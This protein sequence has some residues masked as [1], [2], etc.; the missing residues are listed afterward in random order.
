M[1]LK[2]S[3]HMCSGKISGRNQV[4][5]KTPWIHIEVW[6]F[7]KKWTVCENGDILLTCE[8]GSSNSYLFGSYVK[9]HHS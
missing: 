7:V 6:K 9:K 2:L 4:M 8:V 3:L 5:V 1:C